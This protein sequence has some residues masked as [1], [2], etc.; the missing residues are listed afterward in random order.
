MSC[1]LSSGDN[2]KLSIGVDSKMIMIIFYS[3]MNLGDDLF[4]IHL[5]ANSVHLR[6][7]FKSNFGLEIDRFDE[8]LI[9]LYHTKIHL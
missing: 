7:D 5:F 6:K 8:K 9:T 2:Y 3:A 1:F 4:V